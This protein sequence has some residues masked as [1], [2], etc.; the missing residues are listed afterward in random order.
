MA[1]AKRVAGGEAAAAG[2]ALASTGASGGA[3]STQIS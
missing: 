1:S 2:I 3:P